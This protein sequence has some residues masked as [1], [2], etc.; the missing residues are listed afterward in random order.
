MKKSYLMLSLVA[1]LLACDKETAT[2]PTEEFAFVRLLVNDEQTTRLTVLSPS[3][4]KTETLEAA[5]PKAALYATES[6]RYA[7][8]VHTSS[9]KITTFD[10]G[11]ELH[12]DHVDVKGTSK[13]GVLTGESAK[14][15]HF[16]SQGGHLITFNDGDGSM[17]V[18]AETDVHTAGAVFRSLPT[19]NKAH[20]GAMARFSTGT[21]AVTEKDGTVSGSLPERVKVIDAAGKTVYVSTLATGGIHGNASDGKVA[22]FGSASG[23]LVVEP[24]GGQRLIPYPA[25]F[26]TAWLSTI[27]EAKGT[28]VGYS[29]AIG[30]YEID[31]SANTLRP[32]LESKDLLLTRIDVSK[33]FLLG[34]T[35]GGVLKVVDLST[36][37]L[38]REGPILPAISKEETQKP[39]LAATSRYAYVT[40]PKQGK[41]LRISLNNLS[42]TRSYSVSATPYQLAV[43]GYET[44]ES[45]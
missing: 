43:L 35:Y 24:T 45:H 1:G 27:Y 28:F 18:A 12:G 37:K 29:S 14:P 15:T 17:S 36:R 30:A 16:K 6:G 9:N 8:L 10:S 19:G 31:I 39:T 5:F 44:D 20:H 26:G 34:L 2:P 42:D 11:L 21:Y 23:V 40:Q 3:T 41:V 38:L 13:F 22:V 25:D 32:L 33:R 7:A 4:G